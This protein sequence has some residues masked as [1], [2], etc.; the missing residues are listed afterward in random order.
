MMVP[1]GLQVPLRTCDPSLTELTTLL[2]I[3]SILQILHFLFTSLSEALLFSS[4]LSGHKR[5]Y[6]P[7]SPSPLLCS[8]TPLSLLSSWRREPRTSLLQ[9]PEPPIDHWELEARLSI[10]SFL[11]AQDEQNQIC[12][13]PARNFRTWESKN[14]PTFGLKL[15]HVCSYILIVKLN[16]SIMCLFS[17]CKEHQIIMQ[18]ANDHFQYSSCWL[19][20]S[21][22]G[23]A[24]LK[25]FWVFFF[26]FTS[27]SFA[28]NY[29]L[30][31]LD[32]FCML[33]FTAVSLN[34]IVL[35]MGYSDT[36]N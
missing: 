6:S 35:I 2:I 34:L 28:S 32:V 18:L 19:R 13:A 5:C 16:W 8:L 25:G 33:A 23:A 31:M 17:C 9:S 3:L 14:I 29:I 27:L 22:G 1:A 11:F 30:M 21:K 26:S 24:N 36:A 15:Q 7:V 20:Q 12:F 10:F 4:L